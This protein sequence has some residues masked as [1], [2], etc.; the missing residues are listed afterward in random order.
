MDK[1][2]ILLLVKEKK[3]DLAIEKY[4]QRDQ[5]TEAEEFCASHSH[6]DG[7]L[8]KLLEKYF[9]KYKEAML[10]TEDEG[11]EKEASDYRERGIRLM[12]N[13]ASTGLLDPLV[14][15]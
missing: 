13:N 1:E 15:L 8:T 10:Q 11:K 2:L 9:E 7:L 12:Q 4:I 14:V 3:F 5:F 6:Q